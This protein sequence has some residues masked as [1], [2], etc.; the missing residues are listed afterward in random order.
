MNRYLAKLVS[1][2]EKR[3]Y[4]SNPQNPQNPPQRGFEGFA[5]SPSS[6]FLQSVTPPT[7]LSAE[8][9]AS[10]LA[11]LRAKCPAYVP[12][13]RWRQAIAD[14]TAFI[15]KWGVQAQAFGWTVPE[16]FGLHPV[17]EQP[18]PNYGQLARVD[19]MGLV[20]L[21]RDRPVVELKETTAAYR[22]ANGSILTYY[23]RT[24][25][26]APATEIADAAE[27]IGKPTTE[28]GKASPAKQIDSAG[29]LYRPTE[30]ALVETINAIAQIGRPAPAEIVT[31]APGSH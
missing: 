9:Y 13:D 6:A 5:G 3:A 19:D 28:I 10:A 4:P 1:L 26:A 20:W 8:P 31:V 16:L 18:A 24:A 2:D 14:A 30:A 22:C 15:L 25:P 12:E 23:R 7:E 21:L 29:A 11:S 27:P 17:P